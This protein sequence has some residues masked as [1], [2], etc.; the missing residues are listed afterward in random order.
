MKRDDVGSME[1]E[2]SMKMILRIFEYKDT[3]ERE[4]S[5]VEEAQKIL[6]HMNEKNPNLRIEPYFEVDDNCIQGISPVC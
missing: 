3:I 6:G 2:K 1:K 4:F 5:S